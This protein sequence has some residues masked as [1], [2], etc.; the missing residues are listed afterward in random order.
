MLTMQSR[1][2]DL[3]LRSWSGFDELE[4]EQVESRKER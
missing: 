3:T 4:S 2:L 1:I